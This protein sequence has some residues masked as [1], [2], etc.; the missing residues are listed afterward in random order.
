MASRRWLLSRPDQDVY[1]A[2]VKNLI[3]LTAQIRGLYSSLPF[4]LPT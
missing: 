1:L 2:L 3:K 4:N